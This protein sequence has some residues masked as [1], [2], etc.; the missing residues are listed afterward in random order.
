VT[1][2]LDQAQAQKERIRENLGRLEARYQAEGKERESRAFRWAR[3]SLET[4]NDLRPLRA[5][6]QLD[7]RKA[8]PV[9]IDQFLEDPDFM[10]YLQGD[11]GVWEAHRDRV[12]AMNPDVV[13][14]EA[15]VVETALGGASGTG[16]TTLAWI[17][18][19]YQFYLLT[20]FRNPQ[21]AFGL[22]PITPIVFT[23]QSISQTI[24][25]LVIYNPFK[26]ML[27]SMPYVQR[28]CR[29]DKQREGQIDFTD[30]VHIIP[31]LA[32]G[33]SLQGQ[34]VIGGILDE[35]SF[36]AVIEASKQ[37]AGP[38]GQGGKF[39][40]AEEVYTQTMNRRSRSFGRGG[41]SVGSVCAM[42]NTSYRGDFMDRHLQFIEE[43]EPEGV[44]GD[45]LKRHELEPDDIMDVRQGRTITIQVG[46]DYHATRII[47]GEATED[48]GAQL[49]KVPQR[50]RLEF[51]LDPD[52]ALREIVGIAS[53]AIR[54]FI[55]QRNKMVDAFNRGN[56]LGLESYVDIRDVDLA[57]HGM[58]QWDPDK[59]P[60]DKQVPRYFHVDLSKSRDRC[61]IAVVKPFGMVNVEQSDGTIKTVPSFAVEC[62]IT[63]TPSG[64]AEVEPAVIRDWI[65][66][67]SSE[68]GF[69]IGGVSYDG[70]QSQESLQV[71][72]RARVY[73]V[74][75]S[76]DRKMEQYEYFRSSVYEDRV[77]FCPSDILMEEMIMLE[78]DSVKDKVDHPPKGSKDVAD[79]VCGAIYNC[80]QQRH[81]RNRTEYTNTEGERVRAKGT[82][83]R[84][85]RGK[86]V[87]G[88]K[89]IRKRR[90]SAAEALTEDARA[91][92]NEQEVPDT[93]PEGAKLSKPPQWWQELHGE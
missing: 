1:A 41:I 49:V 26:S 82:A 47:E 64:N 93:L 83:E 62:A 78:Y 9:D 45:R 15:P 12:R 6:R 18:V 7:H 76:V 73:A 14:G 34:A 21:R 51:L 58:P 68:H 36:M 38:R 57:E 3:T 2:A 69:T 13:C 71:L 19:A 66:Q 53:A 29:W 84:P 44:M 77:A 16:K 27:L 75:I 91:P 60:D 20:C 80:S 63:L 46:T 54:P 22:A 56:E 74:E 88:A 43:H 92:R 37:V 17:N 25:K 65:I 30:N 35:L 87:S 33:T 8:F 52:K 59:M 86:R 61:G 5:L 23:M 28:W 11:F 42:S 24:T 72:R 67:L 4:H 70:Y 89:R 39:D 32:R 40:Q 90:R 79:A 48:D 50:Y 31:V 81:Y 10:G 55:R 85:K